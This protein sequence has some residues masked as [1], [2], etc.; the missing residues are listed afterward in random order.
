M[1]NIFPAIAVALLVLSPLPAHGAEITL[2]A[3]GGIRRQMEFAAQIGYKES[4]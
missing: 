4:L 1:K 3:P 2:I